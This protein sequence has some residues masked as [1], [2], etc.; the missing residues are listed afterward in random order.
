[1]RT[2]KLPAEK[3]FYDILTKM[4]DRVEFRAPDQPYKVGD[5]LDVVEFDEKKRSTGRNV[6]VYITN[7]ENCSDALMG[8]GIR[9][10]KRLTVKRLTNGRGIS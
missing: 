2:F 9:N 6:K 3:S 7:I 10:I 1:M 5:I 8:Y 4:K